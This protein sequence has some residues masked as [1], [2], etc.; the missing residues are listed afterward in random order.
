MIAPYIFKVVQDILGTSGPAF[1]FTWFGFTLLSGQPAVSLSPL[2]IAVLLLI[3]G[4]SAAAWVAFKPKAKTVSYN[5]WDCGYYNLDSR[6]EY[7]ATAFS[8]PFRIAFSF[9]LLPYRKSKKLWDSFYHVRS[10][11]YETHTTAVFESHFYQPLL[12]LVYNIALKLRKLQPGSINLYLLY[13]FLTVII[14]VA[15]TGILGR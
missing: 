11:T 6:T 14:L 1:S 9:F 13:I 5:T 2:I 3:L 4:V 10:F 8:K 15:L 12:R 7:T